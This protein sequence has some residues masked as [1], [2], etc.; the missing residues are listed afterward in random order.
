VSI[1]TIFVAAGILVAL[2]AG[3]GLVIAGA[4]KVIAVVILAIILVGIGVLVP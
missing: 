3:L 2:V 4:A 1:G